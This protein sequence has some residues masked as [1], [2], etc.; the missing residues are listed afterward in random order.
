M[1][2][3]GVLEEGTLNVE[4]VVRRAVWRWRAGGC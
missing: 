4:R 2:F 3:W 1:K